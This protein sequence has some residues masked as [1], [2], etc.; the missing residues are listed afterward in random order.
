M[1]VKWLPN[2][3]NV[4]ALDPFAVGSEASQLQADF[5]NG[6]M[7]EKDSGNLPIVTYIT[8]CSTR[9]RYKEVP[10]IHC[11]RCSDYMCYSYCAGIIIEMAK[12]HGCD[13]LITS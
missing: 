9:V 12:L 13:R 6:H 2:L 3:K 8:L 11:I 1:E 5:K 4:T 10:C 7:S